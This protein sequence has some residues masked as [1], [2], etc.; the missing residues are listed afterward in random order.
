LIGYGLP[1]EEVK[2]INGSTAAERG[3][4][5]NYLRENPYEN[6]NAVLRVVRKAFKDWKEINVPMNKDLINYL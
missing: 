6:F 2:N 1:E 5:L 3:K 4:I